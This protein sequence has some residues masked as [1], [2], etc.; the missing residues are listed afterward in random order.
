MSNCV[1]GKEG[2]ADERCNRVRK[3]LG[4][5]MGALILSPAWGNNEAKPLTSPLHTHSTNCKQ[6][7]NKFRWF[8][9]LQ[10]DMPELF[11]FLIQKLI[12]NSLKE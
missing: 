2:R 12:K 4:G 7:K 5:L 8:W 10:A 6:K 3:S 1:Q 11:Q 9:N